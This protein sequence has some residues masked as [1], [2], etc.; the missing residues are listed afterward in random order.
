MVISDPQIQHEPR[1]R[2]ELH[3]FE[4]A[5]LVRAKRKTPV[6]PIL[7]CRF[8]GGDS[9]DGGLEFAMITRTTR[10]CRFWSMLAAR[11][12]DTAG[13]TQQENYKARV[14]GQHPQKSRTYAVSMYLLAENKEKDVAPS[15]PYPC[16][17]RAV[18]PREL[19]DTRWPFSATRKKG[20]E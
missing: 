16:A 12:R 15:S 18:E 14:T 7:W 19:R 5:P 4:V 2:L 13:G 20:R 3:F 8:R 10:Y 9:T 1:I 6:V 11:T 17:T